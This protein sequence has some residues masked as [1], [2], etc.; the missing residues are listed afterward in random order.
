[1]AAVRW[2]IE[3]EDS[4]RILASTGLG[5]ALGFAIL[6]ILQNVGVTRLLGALLL[7]L[8]FFG[9]W[10]SGGYIAYSTGVVFGVLLAQHGIAM[11]NALF[12]FCGV[13]VS[14][15]RIPPDTD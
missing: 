6:W 4:R 8:V 14:I 7:S 12:R 5:F 13:T 1:V 15:A 9:L 3:L 2:L 11:L 10:Y